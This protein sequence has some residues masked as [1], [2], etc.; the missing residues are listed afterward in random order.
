M[1]NAEIKAL[2][3]AGIPGVEARVKGD[4]SHY[5]AIVIGDCFEGKSM[6]NQQKMVY[7][8]LNE[9]ITSGAIH[10]LSIKTYTPEKWET[11]KQLQVGGE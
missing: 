9:H 11:A 5:E 1:E 3:E 4:G 7:A 8:V 2:I 10:A 6:V